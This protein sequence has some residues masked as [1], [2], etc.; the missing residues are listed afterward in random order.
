[1][2]KGLKSLIKGTNIVPNINE[3]KKATLPG[4]TFWA[5][6]KTLITKDLT[7]SQ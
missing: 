5:P 7:R 2:I 6:L 4:A 3:E 1:M